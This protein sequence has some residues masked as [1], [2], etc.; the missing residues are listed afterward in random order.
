[1]DNLVIPAGQAKYFMLVADTTHALAGK[2]S[3]QVSLIAQIA[4]NKGP[5]ASSD[6]KV[7]FWS[8]GGVFYHY[9]P[10]GKSE[11]TSAY[12]HS[13]SYPATGYPMNFGF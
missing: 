9:T 5:L 1:M 2:T 10:T 6:P 3:G 4:G 8:G 12:N 7:M 13:N 11:N